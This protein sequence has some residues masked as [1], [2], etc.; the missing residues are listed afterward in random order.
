MAEV[1]AGPRVDARGLIGKFEYP[2]EEQNYRVEVTV[3]DRSGKKQPVTASL[4]VKV[5]G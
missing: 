5:R 3:R 4:L 2:A 1:P